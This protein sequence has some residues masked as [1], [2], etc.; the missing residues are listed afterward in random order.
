MEFAPDT[1][2]H[3]HRDDTLVYTAYVPPGSLARGR[4]LARGGGT[5]VAPPCIICHG[6]HLQG[7]ATI[8]RLAGRSPTYLLRQLVAFKSGARAGA[9]GALM[10]MVV[11]NLQIGDMIDAAAYAASLESP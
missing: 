8:P 5:T 11:A 9:N 10:R 1:E 2:R 4:L 6:D 7:T 3:E